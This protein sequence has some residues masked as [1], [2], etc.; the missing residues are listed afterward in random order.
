LGL[1]SFGKTPPLRLVQTIP[2]C[3]R[4][5]PR[6]NRCCTKVRA[7][8]LADHTVTRTPVKESTDWG[9]PLAI[10]TGGP[11]QAG[12]AIWA[13]TANPRPVFALLRDSLFLCLQRRTAFSRA[14]C[15][16]QRPAPKIRIKFRLH[17]KFERKG[18]N[19]HK[20]E[21]RTEPP[22]TGDRRSY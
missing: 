14:F 13:A 22:A 19:L 7:G 11:T 2:H 21:R 8:V 5:A 10:L 1:R 20:S 16:G 18:M 15:R 4:I 17:A 12:S 9:T 3:N 6:L